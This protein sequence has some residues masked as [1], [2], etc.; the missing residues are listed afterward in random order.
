MIQPNKYDLE[1]IQDKARYLV[2][3]GFIGRYQPIY[4]LSLYSNFCEFALIER[5]LKQR[6]LDIGSRIVDL[7][8]F[9]ANFSR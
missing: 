8:D 5:E 7:I 9:G 6:N 2:E 3:E 4:A 1:F